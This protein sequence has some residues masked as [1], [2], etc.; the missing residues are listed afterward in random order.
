MKFSIS[1]ILFFLPLA[2]LYGQT[3]SFSIPGV[4]GS[5]GTFN[6]SHSN[7]GV[8][9]GNSRDRYQ[10]GTGGSQPTDNSSVIITKAY[11]KFAAETYAKA[12]QAWNKKNWE[13]VIRL[14]K[15]AK[16]YDPINNT[17]KTAL[18][19]AHGNQEWDKGVEAAN[20]NNYENAIARFKES[21]KYFPDN[22]TLKAN[23]IICSRNKTADEAEKYY[24]KQDWINAAVYYNALWKNFDINSLEAQNRYSECMSN[25]DKMK[26]ADK[27]Y[28]K[29]NAKLAE[30]K[31]ELAAKNI[32][33][34]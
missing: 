14:C 22:S 1:F 12:V 5:T 2:M 20:N 23:I 8:G 9:T 16:A 19:D 31:R 26:K 13:E 24:N 17:Y 34:K 28:L 6:F 15:K 4:D 33:W 11:Q 18:N 21:L 25:I 27:A 3:S 29:F 32:D 7:A 10:T 30:V